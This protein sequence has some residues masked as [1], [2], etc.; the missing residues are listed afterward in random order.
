M[1]KLED[2]FIEI[3]SFKGLLQKDE[4]VNNHQ[5]NLQ[6]LATEIDLGKN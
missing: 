6:V 3:L 4:T 1:K 2:L 5:I